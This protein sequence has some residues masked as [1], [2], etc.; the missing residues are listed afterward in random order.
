MSSVVS[1]LFALFLV[2]WSVVAGVNMVQLMSV[3]NTLAFITQ[4]AARSE[5]VSG[6]WTPTT[7]A[8]VL[9][10]LQNQGFPTSR[11]R[12]DAYS[13]APGA[14]YGAPLIVGL[15]VTDQLE[16]LGANTPITLTVSASDTA[17]SQWVPTAGVTANGA[18]STPSGLTVMSGAA[19]GT[20]GG[21][22]YNGE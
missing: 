18:C 10:T 7:N 15:Q 16:I 21:G 19:Q 22:P 4:Q 11:V 5:S 13:A 20:S 3:H 6:C 1:G 14:P 9:Q 8:V 17:T 12:V 2:M